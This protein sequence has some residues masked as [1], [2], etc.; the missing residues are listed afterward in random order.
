MAGSVMN[1]EVTFVT[2]MSGFSFSLFFNFPLDSIMWSF[3][4][5]M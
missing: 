2:L 1:Q 3:K 5:D 4:N